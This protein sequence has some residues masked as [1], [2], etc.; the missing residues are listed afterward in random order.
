MK[1]LE[2]LIVALRRL[3]GIGPKQAER[4][5]LYLL[6]APEA[7]VAELLSS[8]LDAKGRV[9][10]CARCQNW[11]EEPLCRF[12][13]DENRD[14]GMVCVVEEPQ[15]V[16]AVERTRGFRGVYHVLHGALAPVDGIGPE[17]LKVQE[18]LERVRGGGVRE[19]IVATDPDTEGE[20][21]ALYLAQELHRFPVKVTRIAHGVP[22]G[23]DLDYTDELTLSYAM[24]G[25]REI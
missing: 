25:R 11:S 14:A 10:Y 19:V 6:R 24:S 8:I 3:P 13:S 22:L 5:S 16:L 15:D 18:L 2:K 1:S 12:C 17:A 20:A 4:L 21:T 23:G 7:E 9:K